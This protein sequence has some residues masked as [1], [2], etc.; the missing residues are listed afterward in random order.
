MIIQ[1]QEALHVLLWGE[2]EFK[3]DWDMWWISNVWFCNQMIKSIVDIC[4]H[5]SNCEKLL[6]GICWENSPETALRCPLLK[7]SCFEHIHWWLHTQQLPA[8]GHMSQLIETP[9][10]QTASHGSSQHRR[11]HSEFC[12]GGIYRKYIHIQLLLIAHIYIYMYRYIICIY[13]IYYA[14]IKIVYSTVFA[15][16]LVDRHLHGHTHWWLPH[17]T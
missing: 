9:N 16:H 14:I 11:S 3:K 2:P 8:I 15:F 6:N 13:I 5:Q 1:V 10:S 7:S 4:R 17:D 12:L